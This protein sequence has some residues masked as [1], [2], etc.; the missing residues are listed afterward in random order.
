MRTFPFSKRYEAVVGVK[1]DTAGAAP[2]VEGLPSSSNDKA[3]PL[4]F[5]I[6]TEVAVLITNNVGLVTPGAALTAMMPLN[7]NAPPAAETAMDVQ[8]LGRGVIVVEK[9]SL[10]L[11]FS[12]QCPSLSRSES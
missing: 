12:G 11:S 6:G 3:A 2:F 5:E 4:R 8:V 9:L 7:P 1:T 10:S